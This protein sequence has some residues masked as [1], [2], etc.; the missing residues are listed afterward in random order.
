MDSF[1]QSLHLQQRMAGREFPAK[2][3]LPIGIVCLRVQHLDSRG[4]A[5]DAGAPQ[6]GLR[7]GGSQ[8]DLE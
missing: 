7:N 2:H 8:Q 1:R 5:P 4:L 3:S 6:A